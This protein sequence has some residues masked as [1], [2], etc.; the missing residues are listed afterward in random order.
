M[1]W[2]FKGTTPSQSEIDLFSVKAVIVAYEQA[3]ITENISLCDTERPIHMS[4]E[5]KLQ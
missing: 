2:P 1:Q 5:S 4:R 3:T